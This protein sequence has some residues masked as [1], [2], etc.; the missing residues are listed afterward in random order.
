MTTHKSTRQLLTE[1]RSVHR[2]LGRLLDEID[3]RQ[4][5]P[6]VGRPPKLTQRPVV[7]A[8]RDAGGEVGSISEL[9]AILDVSRK[10]LTR[11]VDPLVAVGVLVTISGDRGAIG[12]RVNEDHLPVDNPE[13]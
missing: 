8:I 3:Q 7:D 5:S 4:P 11:V 1:A 9:A 2:W 12:V 13:V 6:P 10:T